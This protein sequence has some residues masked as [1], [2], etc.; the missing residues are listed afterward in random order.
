MSVAVKRKKTPTTKT[1][2]RTAGLMRER[3]E[4]FVQEIH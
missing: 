1:K 4:T 3:R 2:T